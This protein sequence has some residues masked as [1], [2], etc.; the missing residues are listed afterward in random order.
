MTNTKR[1]DSASSATS[2]SASAPASA[3]FQAHEACSGAE[4][5]DQSQALPWNKPTSVDIQP[6]ALSPWASSN[7]PPKISSQVTRHRPACAMSR[8]K[9]VTTAS[10]PLKLSTSHS[11]GTAHAPQAFARGPKNRVA[12]NTP[13]TARKNAGEPRMHQA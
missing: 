7:R 12:P 11:S 6:S 5:G 2:A 4:P 13:E 9:L 10:S 3:N 1:D 8:P